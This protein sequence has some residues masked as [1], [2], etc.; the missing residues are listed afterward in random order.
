MR[1]G[2][3]I[4]YVAPSRFN[5]TAAFKDRLRLGST[6]GLDMQSAVTGNRGYGEMLDHMGTEVV[7][8][9]TYLP[10]YRWGITVKQNS[11]EAFELLRK[12]RQAIVAFMVIAGLLVFAVAQGGGAV[13]LAADPRGGPGGRAGGLGRPDGQGRGHRLGRGRPA[14]PAPSRR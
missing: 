5:P 9:W 3:E 10:S 1:E 8:A 11:D 12:Q 6:A 13:D 7:T 2:D 14:P 4:T